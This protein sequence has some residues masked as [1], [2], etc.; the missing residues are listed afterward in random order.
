MT[1]RSYLYVPGNVPRMLDK[2]LGRGADA[3]IVDLED[4]VPLSGKAAARSA[5]RDWLS[6][7]PPRSGLASG[8]GPVPPGEGPEHGTQL[9]VRV[10]PGTAGHEDIRAV[11]LPAVTG[12]VVAKTDS[13]GQLAR[14]DEVLSAGERAEGLPR[15]ALRVVPLLESAAAVLRAEEIALAPRVARL[16]LGEADLRADL[17]VGPGGDERELLY[18]RSR[19]VLVSAAAG[20][21]APVAAAS[22]D[23]RD[24]DRLRESTIALARLGFV[25]RSCVHPAQVPVVNEVFTPGPDQ[26]DRARE[27]VERFDRANAGGIGVIVDR[28]GRMVDE[29]VVRQ[30]RR[31]LARSGAAPGGTAGPP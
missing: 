24:L 3:L 23:F 11:C 2:A 21:D 5:V 28:D 8:A 22:T 27:L 20:I 10:N 31:L 14:V 12:V 4:A 18:V 16:Q 19:I 9:W 29:A 13:A 6:G 17:G 15:G 1:P 30:A 7:R 25:G 26:V